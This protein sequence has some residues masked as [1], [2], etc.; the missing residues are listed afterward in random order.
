MRRFVSAIT[1]ITCQTLVAQPGAAD[2]AAD[3]RFLTDTLYSQ[4]TLDATF[5]TL[6]PLLTASISGQLQ[7]QGISVSD[8]ARFVQIFVEEFRE[9]FLAQMRQQM[10]PVLR[11]RFSDADLAGIAEFLRGP[12]GQ[13]FVAEQPN[14]MRAGG[15]IGQRVGAA[16]GIEAIDRIASRADSEGITF[17]GRNG[18]RLDPLQALGGR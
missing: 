1:L 10:Q 15:Q 6:G 9:S 14:L 17:T 8:P 7:A 13:K 4:A 11:D 2:P 3:L 18:E 16:A 12:A 5:E